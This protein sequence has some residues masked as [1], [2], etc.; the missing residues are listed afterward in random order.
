MTDE[1]YRVDANSVVPPGREAVVT[2][3]EDTWGQVPLSG[4]V[5]DPANCVMEWMDT[6]TVTETRNI[7]DVTPKVGVP[8][9][10]ADRVE[11]SHY[12]TVAAA[13][14]WRLA[15]DAGGTNISAGPRTLAGIIGSNSSGSTYT[16]GS[17]G[18]LKSHVLVPGIKSQRLNTQSA[19]HKLG[20]YWKDEGGVSDS[21]TELVSALT[22]MSLKFT[23]TN[24]LLQCDASYDAL[25][26]V[27]ADDGAQYT[28]V[29][30]LAAI[31]KIGGVGGPSFMV[32]RGMEIMY[33]IPDGTGTAM[34]V[35]ITGGD[36]TLTRTSKQ[37]Y[38]K[39]ANSL[40]STPIIPAAPTAATA[41]T[42]GHLAN[43]SYVYQ[44]AYLIVPADPTQTYLTQ[45]SAPVTQAAS[46]TGAVA[47]N[48]LTAGDSTL[49]VTSTAVYW[50][51]MDDAGNT[52][53][54]IGV[55][56]STDSSPKQFID[57]GTYKLAGAYI[58]AGSPG[59]HLNPLDLEAGILTVAGTFT[60][61]FTGAHAGTPYAEYRYF[62]ELGSSANTH[63]VKWSDR[64]GY[65]TEFE[66]YP[67]VIDPYAQNETPEGLEATITWTAHYAAKALMADTPTLS[68]FKA[69]LINNLTSSLC[70]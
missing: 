7:V 70:H 44:C 64:N 52:P 50:Y 40:V 13:F 5:A 28:E 62:A 54:L 25:F 29:A 47:V 58:G 51:R 3:I 35:P 9:G 60:V 11:T 59:D 30:T 8:S 36:L 6:F 2:T 19:W 41:T 37:V 17:V 23:W 10:V 46:S 27:T 42:G 33:S 34:S 39:L 48:T 69:T 49:P 14:P 15:A 32:T 68:I 45:L 61:L 24:A 16:P 12:S 67:I 63:H 57:D 4:G 18:S 22:P 31:N 66:M 56:A 38:A 43:G 26:P 21:Q 20:G 65:S 1:V 55:V 53:R